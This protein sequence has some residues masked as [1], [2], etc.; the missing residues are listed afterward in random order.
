MGWILLMCGISVEPIKVEWE[1]R[2]CGDI[3][4]SS[5]DPTVLAKRA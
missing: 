1:C 2:I 4:D 3:F 5:T